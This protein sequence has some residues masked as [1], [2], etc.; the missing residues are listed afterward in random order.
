MNFEDLAEIEV[1]TLNNLNLKKVI[2]IWRDDFL[3]DYLNRR[4]FCSSS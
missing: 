2:Y 1:F 4:A 3:L